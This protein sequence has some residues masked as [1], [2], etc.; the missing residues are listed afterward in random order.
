[1][2]NP[3][4]LPA[5]QKRMLVFLALGAVVFFL[6]AYFPVFRILAGKW[7]ESED[8]SHAFLTLPIILY[9][10]FQ[11]RQRVLETPATFTPL[12][13]VTLL[14]A[15]ALYYFGLLTEVHTVIAL[16][17]YLAVL[18]TVV[19]LFGI[20]SLWV[21]FTPL[22]LLL[23][24]I[25]F[26]EQLYIQLTFP[27]QLKVSQ[28]SEAIINL[29]GI[30]LHRA[31]NVLTIPQKSFEVVEACSGLRSVITLLTLSVVMGYFLLERTPAKLLLVAASIPVAIFV[32]LIRVVVIVLAFYY[33]GLDL[34]EGT[35]HTVAGLGIFLIAL[36]TLF[37]LQRILEQWEHKQK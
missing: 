23:M 31:G 12:G 17:M 1:M 34:Y 20:R 28:M 26:P 7:A 2:H 9:M 36:V 15:S 27:L 24:L 21:L 29:V 30:P 11:N 5:G 3:P 16:A 4:L 18:G 19:F 22:L 32:N 35:L 10:V 14:L 33:F 25:P 37:L 6:V 8:Y 13:L